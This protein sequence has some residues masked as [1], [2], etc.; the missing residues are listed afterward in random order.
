V[1][2]E[3]IRNLIDMLVAKYPAAFSIHNRKPLKIGI[4]H[5]SRRAR[6]RGAWIPGLA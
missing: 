3:T 4:H 1:S 6:D 5:D 2:K